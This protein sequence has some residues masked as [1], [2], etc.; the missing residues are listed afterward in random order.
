MKPL[1]GIS[2]KVLSALVFTMMSAVLKTLMD[3]YPTGEVV[4]FRSSFAILPLWLWLA[5]KGDLINGLRTKTVVGHFKRGFLGTGAM[6]LG[7][8]ALSFLPL[9]DAI[10]IGYASPLILV[11]LAAILLKEKIRA[12]R[13][14][15][16]AVGFIGVMIMLSPYLT[17]ETFAGGILAGPSL[18]AICAFVGAVCS[19]GAMVQV[20]RLTG[21]EKTGAIVFYF[22][23]LASGLSFCTILLG[24][25]MPDAKD[26]ALFVLG[27]ILGGIGQILLTES[28]RYADA[29]VIAPFDYTTMVWALLFGW[30]MFGD[31][32][33]PTILVG[34]AI[35]AATGLFIV[36]REHRLGLERSEEL[37]VASQKPGA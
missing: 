33:T 25:N 37:K 32:P 9:H 14:T 20:R 17:P 16:V 2:L 13:W 19:A 29:S 5:W 27:G 4:F 30:L 11:I 1:L 24:W 28:Y 15:A 18:G 34:A 6:F 35:V 36:W 31:L 26:L 12:Y 10:A 23:I 3:R 8:A 22:F 7:F 21:T